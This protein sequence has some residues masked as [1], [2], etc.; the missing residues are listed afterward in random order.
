MSETTKTVS[1]SRYQQLIDISRDLASTLDLDTLLFRIVQV[2]ADLSQAEEASI[3]LYDE[4]KKDL[5]FQAA[6]NIDNPAIRGLRVPV[7]QSVAGWIV[8]HC[9]PLIIE[10][11]KKDER[12]FGHIN[13]E[14][15]LTTQS[16]LSVAVC[17]GLLPV[18]V[19]PDLVL[20]F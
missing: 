3:L 14:S 15:A 19:Q 13:Q 5:R 1:L 12:H 7:K 6:T 20:R 9:E 2:A 10:D 4:G 18:Y 16:L 11:V 8:T 17:P